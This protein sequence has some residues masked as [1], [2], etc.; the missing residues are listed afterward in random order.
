MSIA[1]DSDL[2]RGSTGDMARW[3]W[4]VALAGV[5]C[6]LAVCGLALLLLDARGKANRYPP[7]GTVVRQVITASTGPE[8][9]YR[10][11]QSGM[12]GAYIIQLGTNPAAAPMG[13]A[14]AVP[15][16]SAAD[17]RIYPFPVVDAQRFYVQNLSS[18]TYMTVALRTGLARRVDHVVPPGLY[19]TIRQ[20]ALSE[21]DPDIIVQTDRVRINLQGEVRQVFPVMPR[22]REPFVLLV[23]A[24]YF[25]E[26]APEEAA[27][28]LTPYLS[29]LTYIVVSEDLDDT[30]I[31]DA[32]RGRA[33]EFIALMVGAG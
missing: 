2:Q 30:S 7:D 15:T 4:T 20:S 17:G 13:F 26:V 21:P 32:V 31:D 16:D 33:G 24:S 27:R 3:S 23:N 5:A 29:L 6:A 28:S 1:E 11:E 22:T 9:M 12:K 18:E 19:D 8:A 25:S 14:S 10:L